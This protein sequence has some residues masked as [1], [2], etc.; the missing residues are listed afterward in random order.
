MALPDGLKATL[1]TWFEGRVAGL[2]NFKPKPEPLHGYAK[3]Y[4][5]PP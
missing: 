5:E 1:S 3:I 2:A 4:G